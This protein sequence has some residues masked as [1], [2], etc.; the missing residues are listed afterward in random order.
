MSSG[1][2]HRQSVKNQNFCTLYWVGNTIVTLRNPCGLLNNSKA[3]VSVV[4][5]SIKSWSSVSSTFLVALVRSNWLIFFPSEIFLWRLRL[6]K[7]IWDTDSNM[8][9]PFDLVNLQSI[10][11]HL[12][13][14]IIT[15]KLIESYPK[16]TVVLPND[17]I[18]TLVSALLFKLLHR[19]LVWQKKFDI[20]ILAGVCFFLC[21]L[22]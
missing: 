18:I 16:F 7:M 9:R 10:Y 8:S 22:C 5:C 13:C 12:S 3:L 4:D 15:S 1:K 11:N 14:M 2:L 17:G 6:W 20:K 21:M 19:A